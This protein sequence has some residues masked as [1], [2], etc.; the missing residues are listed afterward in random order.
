MDKCPYCG[1]DEFY[2][3]GKPTGYV[4]MNERFD[5]VTAE[6]DHMFD[7]VNFNLGKTRW[8]NN[9]NRKLPSVKPNPCVTQPESNDQ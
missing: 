9:C 6:N 7:Y 8:C 3:K 2:R 5:G 1:N 4:I